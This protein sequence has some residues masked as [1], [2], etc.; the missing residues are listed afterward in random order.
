MG[1]LINSEITVMSLTLRAYKTSRRYEKDCLLLAIVILRNRVSLQTIVSLF[2][3]L[4]LIQR[5]LE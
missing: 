2:S 1:I 3:V 4:A 5:P